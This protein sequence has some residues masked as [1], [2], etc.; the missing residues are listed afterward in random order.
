[1]EALRDGEV[2]QRSTT[3]ANGS[4]ILYFSR[5]G[6]F[7]I[8]ANRLGYVPSRPESVEV[9]SRELVEVLLP[10][11]TSPIQL[12]GIT[13]E[14]RRA[15]P[16]REATFAG[17][18]A[19]REA[20]RSVGTERVVVRGDPEMEVSATVRDVLRW[21][22]PTRGCVAYYVDG[23]PR[24]EFLWGIL[25]M[26]VSMLEGIEYYRSAI[27]A[28]LGFDPPMDPRCSIVAVWRERM[29]RP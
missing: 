15:D 9:R 1:V 27:W 14:A 26:P 20:A 16:R 10:L 29:G 23:L 17:L 4:F 21:F 22:L 2:V 11:S 18:F 25:D 3:D 13:V 8:R 5:S 6:L 24:S 19:R 7:E 12:E 28:P